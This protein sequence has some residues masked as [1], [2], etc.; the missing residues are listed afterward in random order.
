[1]RAESERHVSQ[2]VGTTLLER[3]VV[4]N[5]YLAVIAFL[6]WFF[7]IAGSPLPH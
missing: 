3:I 6:A 5:V 2:R 1:M 4:I 7:L